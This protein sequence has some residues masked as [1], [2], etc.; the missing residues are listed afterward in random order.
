MVGALHRLVDLA[1]VASTVLGQEVR[2][3]KEGQVVDGDDG[4][5]M[6]VEGGDEIRAVKQIKPQRR[7]LKAQPPLL[8]AVMTGGPE[9]DSFEMVVVGD[10]QR[11]PPIAEDE[12]FI[13]LINLCQALD[14]AQGILADAGVS[15][16]YQAGVYPNVHGPSLKPMNS[17]AHMTLPLDPPAGIKN[18]GQLRLVTHDQGN[19][20]TNFPIVKL[21]SCLPHLEADDIIAPR[22]G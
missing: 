20:S 11:I 17:S 4:L 3:E 14:K 5:E 18:G 16:I 9:V 10:G 8:E 12:E 13:L 2:V 22:Q 19:D 1:V 7:K 15:V 21:T 6:A